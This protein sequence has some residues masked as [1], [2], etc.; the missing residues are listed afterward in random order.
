MHQKQI[1]NFTLE[2]CY[3]LWMHND[4]IAVTCS[5]LKQYIVMQQSVNHWRKL[6][7][8][9]IPCGVY[10]KG[11]VGVSTGKWKAR[12]L[13]FPLWLFKCISFISVTRICPSTRKHAQPI[14]TW[15]DKSGLKLFDLMEKSA[16][17]PVTTMFH[18][19]GSSHEGTCSSI[20]VFSRRMHHN[21]QK[22]DGRGNQ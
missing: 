8:T 13:C 4:K 22:E 6:C 12:K 14:T 15:G 1:T 5:V 16:I 18:K 19:K 2:L 10:T 21:G 20:P 7:L 3:P 9:R 17:D 11:P